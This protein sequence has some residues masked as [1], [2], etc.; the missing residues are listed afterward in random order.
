[1]TLSPL[2]TAPPPIPAHALLALAAFIGGTVQ[3]LL[4]KGTAPHRWLGRAWVGAM[5]VV[6]TSGLF[7]HTIRLVGP[8]SPIHILSV[9]TLVALVDAVRRARRGDIAGHQRGMILLYALALV[10][11]GA[12]TLLPGR[13]MHAVIFG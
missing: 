7:I 11:T 9:V 13:V 5:A 3:M 10:L 2:L 8:F 1:M 4:P 6:A 12:F